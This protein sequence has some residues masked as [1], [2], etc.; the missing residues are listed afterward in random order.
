M[1]FEERDISETR[2]RKPLVSVIVPV[3]NDNERLQRC[4]SALRAQSYPAN[5]FEVIVVDNSSEQAPEWI[6]VQYPDI[7][8]G[9]EPQP[10]SYA[11]RNKGIKLAHG[12]ILAFT[13]SDCVPTEDWVE[14]GVERLLSIPAAGIVG[15]KVEFFFHDDQ[16][17]TAVELY[18]S[19][20]YMQQDK[21][22]TNTRYAA[23][24][25]LF[26]L[27]EVIERVGIFDAS[28]GSGGDREW[29]QRVDAR[30]YDLIY[31]E[32]VVVRHPARHTLRQL[33]RKKVRVVGGIHQWKKQTGYAIYHFEFIKT[34]ALDLSPPVRFAR[35][36]VKDNRVEGGWNKLKVTLVFMLDKYVSAWARIRL[37]LGANPER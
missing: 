9:Q 25:N 2:H 21:N 5:R 24:A 3:F 18:D 28:L 26:T 29:G 8:L 15:G 13:D 11:A 4:L 36:L 10:G 37:Q 27:R 19:I 22:I 12:K 20:R 1:I 14:K 32:D 6:S 34:I 7:I 16:K 23:T 33:F 30:G 17:P 31:G 35:R